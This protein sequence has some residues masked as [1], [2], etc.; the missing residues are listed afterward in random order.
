MVVYERNDE[1]RGE[2]SFYSIYP[3]R[4]KKIELI[5]IAEYL[6]CCLY[7]F[8][9]W[10]DGWLCAEKLVMCVTLIPLSVDYDRRVPGYCLRRRRQF[11]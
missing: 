8:T 10:T 2:L 5:A 7:L 1:N 3:E 6:H 9:S 11:A 4:R